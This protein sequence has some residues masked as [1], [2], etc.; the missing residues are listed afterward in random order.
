MDKEEIIEQNL[1]KA[2][3]EGL[4]ATI[5]KVV[6][7]RGKIIG[8]WTYPDYL[9][10]HMFLETA[11]K[12]RGIFPSRKTDS[13]FC[14]KDLSSREMAEKLNRIGRMLENRDDFIGGKNA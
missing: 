12:L 3:R 6:I 5:V 4:G 10:R 7:Y 8:E 1:L 13:T 11:L 9:T 14:Q 2:L